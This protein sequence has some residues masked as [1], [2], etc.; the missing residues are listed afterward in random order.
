MKR[1]TIRN[2]TLALVGLASLTIYILACT[3]FSPDDKRVLYPTFDSASR[4][5]GVAVYDRD[6]GRSELLFVPHLRAGEELGN[7]APLLRPQWSTDGRS[8]LVAWP[9]TDATADS[10]DS[11][12]LAVLPVGGRGPVR[13]FH[14]VGLPKTGPGLSVPL[15]VIGN[16]LFL[17]GESN[18]VVRLDLVTGQVKRQA[19]AKEVI[20]Y[21]SPSPE[22][23]CYATDRNAEGGLEV[24][25][26]DPENFALTPI[27]RL[28]AEESLSLGG[29]G[30]L[31]AL[32]RDGR[33]AAFVAHNGQQPEILFKAS[34]K[35]ARKSPKLAADDE[36]LSLAN[37]QFSPRGGLLYASFVR[38]HG[39]ATNSAL[40]FLEVP[41][42]GKPARR[43]TLIQRGPNV[44]EE[45]AL[46]FQIGV[47]HDGKTLAVA[48]TYLAFAEGTFRSDD[49]A[50]FLVDLSDPQRTVTKVPIP[51]PPKPKSK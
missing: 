7:K 13:F 15:C 39:D 8:V 1:P 21:P 14:L 11:L 12:S 31:V 6:A 38:N 40:G 36:E 42:N 4:R 33:T 20:P 9:G 47:S 51:L 25:F 46:F 28:D 26:L 35:P 16:R 27:A 50:L 18:T 48:S 44:K 23:P 24:G 17:Q 3:S 43:V 2:A 34:G 30:G 10:D 37:A 22:R 5:V 45:A 29:D 41:T 49:C 19:C 32:S